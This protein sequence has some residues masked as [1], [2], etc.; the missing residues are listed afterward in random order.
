MEE[1]GILLGLLWFFAA[2]GKQYWK[3]YELFPRPRQRM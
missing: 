2:T 1:K 3:G